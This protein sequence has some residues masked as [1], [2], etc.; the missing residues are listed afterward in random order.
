ME[1]TNQKSIAALILGIL[2]IVI[3]YIG[4]VLG[5]I[6]IVLGTKGLREIDNHANQTGRGIA[7]AGRVCSI[8]GIC[9]QTLLICFVVLGVV[10]F[11]TF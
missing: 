4:L 2:S 10:L 7:V 1:E 9:L 6:G 5:I 11:L 8:V 3:P